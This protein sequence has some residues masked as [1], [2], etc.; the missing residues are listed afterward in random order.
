MSTTHTFPDVIERALRLAVRAHAGQTRKTDDTP[1]ITHPVA[2]ALYLTQRG[3]DERTVAAALVH[4]VLE[5]TEVT[6]DALRAELGEEVYA[7]VAAL[8]HDDTL[9][10]EDKKLAYIESV[11]RGSTAVKLV[12]LADKI[13]NLKC[14]IEAFEQEGDSVWRHFNR[15]YEKKVWFE[16]AMV[17][18]F[19]ESWEHPCVE[20]YAE[21][22]KRLVHAANAQRS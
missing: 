17:A 22:L 2:V 7:I 12:A 1:Y 4:D 21:L 3:A 18:M 13:H 11:R 5:D 6:S 20:E 10:W 8:T 19:R 16:E 14:L 15:G 9:S